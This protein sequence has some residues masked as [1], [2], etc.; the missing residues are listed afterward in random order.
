M[1]VARRVQFK[2]KELQIV[3]VLSVKTVSQ[4]N[5]GAKHKFFDSCQIIVAIFLKI[6]AEKCFSISSMRVN[7]EEIFR[8]P[9]NVCEKLRRVLESFSRALVPVSI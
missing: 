6:C 8:L 2:I 1:G 3:A 4:S 7:C 5:K 9:G